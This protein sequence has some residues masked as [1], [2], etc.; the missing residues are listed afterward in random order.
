VWTK[1]KTIR[2]VLDCHKWGNSDDT[3]L[4]M[5]GQYWW[6]ID[7]FFSFNFFF[8]KFLTPIYNNTD[9][10][11]LSVPA[12]LLCICV[13]APATLFERGYWF[14]MLYEVFTCLS[15]W[16]NKYC[17]EK[18]VFRYFTISYFERASQFNTYLYTDKMAKPSV[19]II[20]PQL[21]ATRRSP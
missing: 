19:V 15:I 16:R 1:L 5:S 21:E 10:T 20:I 13:F 17:V 12:V 9:S 3:T 11:T 8:I 18:Q 4:M 14:L 7:L 6:C 2:R